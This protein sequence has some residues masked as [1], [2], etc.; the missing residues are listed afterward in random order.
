[1]SNWVD[2]RD[3]KASVSMERTLA[4]YGIALRQAGANLRG[5][6]PLPTHAKRSKGAG[7]FSV[8]PTKNAWACQSEPCIAARDGRR[9]GNVLDFVA[10]MESCT[11]REA[12]VLL[13]ERFI[14]QEQLAPETK[15]E[16]PAPILEPGNAP[17]KFR[18]KGVEPNHPYL[19]ERGIRPETARLFGMGYFGG[20]GLMHGRIVVPIENGAGELVAYAGRWPVGDVPEGED[21]YK[22][23]P[24]FHASAVLFNLHRVP[25]SEVVTV[26]EGFFDVVKL[27]QEGFAVVGL[28]GSSLSSRQAELLA[29][30][31]GVRL[32][33]DGDEAGR[34][35]SR[36]IAGELASSTW[37]KSVACP[38]GK[39]PADLSAPELHAL[40]S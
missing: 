28:M 24:G 38:P 37:V 35:A 18:L 33:F 31:K 16:K 14:G 2:F 21:K 7:S 15:G 13:Q 29:R 3:V 39:D 6:C 1:M 32:F 30:F 9:G 11:V 40:L 17:L 36:Q 34:K 25:S 22:L 23:P 8:N 19:T 4:H 20:R 5:H 12:A 10:A 27:H 26:V